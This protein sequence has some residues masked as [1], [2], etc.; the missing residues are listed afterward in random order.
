MDNRSILNSIHLLQSFYRTSCDEFSTE[1]LN[2]GLQISKKITDGDDYQL[3]KYF[4]YN[5]DVNIVSKLLLCLSTGPGP[6]IAFNKNQ[7]YKDSVEE[8]SR[9]L[10]KISTS[11]SNIVVRLLVKSLLQSNSIVMGYILIDLW[12]LWTR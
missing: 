4:M 12:S 7:L 10:I 6:S 11:D 8:L 5:E 2:I 1:L 9:L 3:L